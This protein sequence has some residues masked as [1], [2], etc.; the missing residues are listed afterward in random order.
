MPSKYTSE[1]KAGAVE[2]PL[3]AQADL[4]AA[5]G[6]VSRVA[7]ELNISRE[8]LRRNAASA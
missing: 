5:R 7:D 2:L 1:L 8:N 3:H 4:D 6:A